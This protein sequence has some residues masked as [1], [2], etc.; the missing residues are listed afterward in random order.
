VS[1][2]LSRVECSCWFTNGMVRG[3]VAGDS[4]ADVGPASVMVGNIV[5]GN[6]LASAQGRDMGV[7][8]EDSDNAK[9]VCTK[10]SSLCKILNFLTYVNFM[11]YICLSVS[12]YLRDPTVARC[13]YFGPCD[14]YI[15]ELK[16]LHGHL[17][18]LL[19]AT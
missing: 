9:K 7:L 5:Q 11:H 18:V 2:S 14:I 8:D 15:I 4:V 19:A 17:A 10:A 12:I 3:R 1:Y 13:Q 16:R 6:R